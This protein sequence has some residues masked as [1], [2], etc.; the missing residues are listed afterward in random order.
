[1]T[2]V[3]WNTF[4]TLRRA[5][6]KVVQERADDDA[7]SPLPD[8]DYQDHMATTREALLA[9]R[10]LDDLAAVPWVEGQAAL[11]EGGE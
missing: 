1:M 5:L 9:A 10:T 7:F 8:S 11:W 2:G 6:L 4:E 3:S